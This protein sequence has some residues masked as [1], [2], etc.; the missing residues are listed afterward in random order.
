MPGP[1]TTAALSAALTVAAVAIPLPRLP[2][3][4]RTGSQTAVTRPLLMT[5]AAATAP[6]WGIGR[7]TSGSEPPF[8][9][10]VMGRNR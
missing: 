3:G 10:R 2:R 1:R 5:H 7:F 9:R 6:A 8:D 4:L